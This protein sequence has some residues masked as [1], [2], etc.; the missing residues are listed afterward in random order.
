MPSKD[1]RHEQLFETESARPHLSS[2]AALFFLKMY[3]GFRSIR[4]GRRVI[5]GQTGPA[6]RRSIVILESFRGT[7]SHCWTSHSRLGG[8][9]NVES[10]ITF[11]TC[12]MF[13]HFGCS[14]I[15]AIP[16]SESELRRVAQQVGSKGFRSGSETRPCS[17]LPMLTSMLIAICS[18]SR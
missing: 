18:A 11:E 6:R 9:P 10:V 16:E 15:P 12:Y 14:D 13:L 8:T 3:L 17:T 7:G 1:R 2:P 4:N 5:N